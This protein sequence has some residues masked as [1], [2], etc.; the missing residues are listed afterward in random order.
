[1]STT[2]KLVSM[3]NQ[4]ATNLATED[5]PVASTLEHI[6]LFWDPRMKSLI[7]ELG[8]SGLSPVGEQVVKRLSESMAPIR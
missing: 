3:V 4:I 7:T 8:V 5:D 1:M 2:D 6:Q